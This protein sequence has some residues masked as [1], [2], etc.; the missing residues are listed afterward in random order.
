MLDKANLFFLLTLLFFQPEELDPITH[1]PLLAI[2]YEFNLQG[3]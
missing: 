3:E 2:I 1:E